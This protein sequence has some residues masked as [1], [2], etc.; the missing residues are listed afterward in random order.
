MWCQV[1]C[2]PPPRAELAAGYGMQRRGEERAAV[3]WKGPW[4]CGAGRRSVER[5]AGARSLRRSAERAAG[6]RSE[7]QGR[8]LG[9]GGAERAAGVRNRPPGYGVGRKGAERAAGVWSGPPRHGA[10]DVV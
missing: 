8:G 1:V 7:P 5:A 6:V 10:A 3:A 9:H 4:G 2:S